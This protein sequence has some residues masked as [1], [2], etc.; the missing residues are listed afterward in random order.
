MKVLLE[1][2]RW[3]RNLLIVVMWFYNPMAVV[4]PRGITQR[5]NTEHKPQFFIETAQPHPRATYGPRCNSLSVLPVAI[6]R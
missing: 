2:I 1:V 4:S 5:A 3:F 6:A